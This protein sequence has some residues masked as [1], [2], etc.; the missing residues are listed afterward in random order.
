MTLPNSKMKCNF[1][2]EELEHS[3]YHQGGFPPLPTLGH[4]LVSTHNDD[5]MYLDQKENSEE[6]NKKLLFLNKAT[7]AHCPLFWNCLSNFFSGVKNVL[8]KNNEQM[9]IYKWPGFIIFLVSAQQKFNHFMLLTPTLQK[10][11]SCI[12]YW[13]L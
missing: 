4:Q 2:R 9:A 7:N 13:S 6:K 12:K 5:L 11:H 8:S 10:L 3:R 1:Y